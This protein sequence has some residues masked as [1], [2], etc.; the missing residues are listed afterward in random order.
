[1]RALLVASLAALSV[2]SSV[3]AEDGKLLLSG[4]TTLIPI[5]SNAIETFTNQYQTWDRF[6][7]ALPSRPIVIETT[8]GG[9]GQGVRSVLDNIADAGMVSRDLRPQ[10]IE[11]L[12]AHQA[13]RV[14]VDAVAIAARQDNPLHGIRESLGMDE[15]QS[16]FSGA[17][18]SYRDFDPELPDRE[19]V[20]L[21]RDSSAGSAVMVQEQILGETPVSDK[22][23]QMSSQGALLRTLQGN[24]YSFAYISV[25]LINANADLKA[26]AVEG[27][28]PTDANLAEGV[29]GLSR[30]ML[31]V[32]RDGD[33][34][35]L[36]AF[37][38]YMVSPEGQGIV[39]DLGYIPVSSGQ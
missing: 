31:I 2:V 22:A 21:V 5:V 19:V 11:A 3:Q 29:Y 4:S 1:M 30:P 7:P 14:G 12:G 16:L 13:V 8:G 39:A 15:L 26:F 36:D 34:A 38:R 9:S 23:L 24:P 27:V 35:Y 37:M 33:N 20:L 6:D 28:A 17:I 32:Y 25:G 18:R 10:E